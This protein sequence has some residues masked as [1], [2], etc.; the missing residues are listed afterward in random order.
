MSLSND[1]FLLLTK[2][3]QYSDLNRRT[4]RM[5]ACLSNFKA[6]GNSNKWDLNHVPYIGL[7]LRALG[8]VTTYKDT[9]KYA[10][11]N[12]TPVGKAKLLEETQRRYREKQAQID[13]QE[14]DTM[15]TKKAEPIKLTQYAVFD[16]NEDGF[17]RFDTLPAAEKAAEQWAKESPGSEQVI[18]QVLYSIKAKVVTEKV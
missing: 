11:W 17:Q 6:E 8:L 14:R 7:Q 5:A 16:T 13:A 3:S 2:I 4:D 18:M 12:I 15:P 10:L 1:Q 9:N